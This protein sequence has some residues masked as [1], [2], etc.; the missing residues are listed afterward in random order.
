MEGFDGILTLLTFFPLVGVIAILLLKPFGREDDDLIKRIAI[1]TS[2][3]TFIISL[4]VLFRYD[5]GEAGLQLVDNA[6][7]IAPLNIRYYLA[8]DGLSILMILLTTII[9]MLAISG[10]WTAIVEQ[11]KGY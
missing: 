11:V 5:A 9:S 3:V 10:S 6:V 8:V 1:G 4:W 2:V 7:W